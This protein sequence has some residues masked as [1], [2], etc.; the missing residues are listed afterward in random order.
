MDFLGKMYF[1]FTE[2]YLQFFTEERPPLHVFLPQAFTS[3][4]ASTFL[5]DV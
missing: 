4:D 1:P 3:V 2:N 5:V